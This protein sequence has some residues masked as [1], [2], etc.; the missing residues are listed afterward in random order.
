MTEQTSWVQVSL[1]VPQS[2]VATVE[3]ALL[4]AGALSVTLLDTDDVPVLEPL[5]GE[6][7]LWPNVK[8]VACSTPTMIR[9]PS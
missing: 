1:T 5:P 6:T 3:D 7:P 8:V 4:E 9:P 2:M